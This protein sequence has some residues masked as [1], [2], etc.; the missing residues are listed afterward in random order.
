MRQSWSNNCGMA[1]ISLGLGDLAQRD[2]F[3]AGRQMC[4]GLEV[5]ATIVQVP[6][7]T[8]L[9]RCPGVATDAKSNEI[10]A[11][12]LTDTLI[13]CGGHDESV[14]V[15]GIHLIRFGRVQ[16]QYRPPGL[17]FL[18]DISYRQA[19][20]LVCRIA[21]EERREG[22]RRTQDL[23]RREV[24]RVEGR[25][26]GEVSGLRQ[27]CLRRNADIQKQLECNRKLTDALKDRASRQDQRLEDHERALRVLTEHDEE[28]RAQL[29]ENIAWTAQLAERQARTESQL[30]EEISR[31]RAERQRQ[32]QSVQFQKD[33]ATRLLGD[34][35]RAKMQA[36]GLEADLAALDSALAR[37]VQLASSRGHEQA[38]LALLLEV[39]NKVDAAVLECARRET[40]TSRLRETAR[41]ALGAA[42]M[43]LSQLREDRDVLYLFDKPL[44]VLQTA[45]APNGFS[46]PIA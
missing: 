1:V 41:L 31:R 21:R 28:L 17:C 20:N 33:L 23:L 26:Q 12:C 44:T 39:Q 5:F 22:D 46:G 2:P 42:E 19:E 29:Q 7:T 9:W 38:S 27:E 36:V 13:K 6:Q 18:R 24:Q 34:L 25:M 35:D 4:R 14:D 16:N 10:T 8:Y 15:V 45:L 37:G 3:F 11:I 43:R 30:Q 32:A 40:E